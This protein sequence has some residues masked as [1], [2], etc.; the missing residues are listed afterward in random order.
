MNRSAVISEC[1]RYRYRLF[2]EWKQ[3]DLMPILWVMLNPSTADA[4]IDDPTIRRCIAFS[5]AWGYGSMLVGNLFAFRSPYPK[6]LN[7]M[8]ID[9]ARGPDNWKHLQEMAQN[10]AKVICAWGKHG[11]N[12]VPAEVWSPGGMWCL[13]MNRDGSPKHPLYV[14]GDTQLVPAMDHDY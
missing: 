5:Q 3:S 12:R 14:K 2:R 1:G 7:A 9:L 6:E 8:A 4:S 11:G 10:S 13:G